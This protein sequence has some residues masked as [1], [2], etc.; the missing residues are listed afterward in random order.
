MRDDSALIVAISQRERERM[1][2]RE[3][4]R[5]DS[6]LVIAISQAGSLRV[7]T[8]RVVLNKKKKMHLKCTGEQLNQ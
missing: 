1:R 7:C 2:E 8:V 4:E 5:H 3:R 6:A